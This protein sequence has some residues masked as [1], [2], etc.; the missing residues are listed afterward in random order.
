MI[1]LEGWSFT[2]KLYPRS[3]E[4]MLP[5]FSPLARIICVNFCR[6]GEVDCTKE[7]YM[8]GIGRWGGAIILC[9]L[10]GAQGEKARADT[11]RAG[12]AD[13][14]LAKGERMRYIGQA[15]PT[16]AKWQIFPTHENRTYRES[17]QNS[18]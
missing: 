2:I 15:A 8:N 5:F 13:Y 9:A 11:Q 14:R 16:R 6:G 10:P 4:C 17:E 3:D 1:S 7:L 18:R 12:A